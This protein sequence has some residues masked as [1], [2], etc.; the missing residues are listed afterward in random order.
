[1]FEK[2]DHP[3]LVPFLVAI[4]M[5]FFTVFFMDPDIYYYIFSGGAYEGIAEWFQFGF[6]FL[7]GFIFLVTG[8]RLAH[9]EHG[10]A[11]FIPL[12]FGLLVLV[13]ALE[14]ISWGQKIFN[15]TTPEIISNINTQNELTV[16][17]LESVQPLLP[18][19]YIMAGV[20]LSSLPFFR[21][22]KIMKLLK[23]D[24][25]NYLPPVRLVPYFISISIFYFSFIYINPLVGGVIDNHQE[26]FETLLSFGIF[27]WSLS[28]RDLE[29][30]G[31]PRH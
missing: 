1:M 15:F 25:S 7:A 30:L 5:P 31:H 13:V 2:R 8:S 20:L 23:P 27:L 22:R 26:V 19:A 4:G 14:E 16:H 9:N 10:V 3:T 11:R 12:M 17:N 24:L 18:Q 28:I 21:N 6:Y 29:R